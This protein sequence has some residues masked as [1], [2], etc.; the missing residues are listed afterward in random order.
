[1]KLTSGDHMMIK[2]VLPGRMEMNKI[3]IGSTLKKYHVVKYT[4]NGAYGQIHDTLIWVF[5]SRSVRS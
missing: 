3:I 2:H 5:S 1:M 4:D